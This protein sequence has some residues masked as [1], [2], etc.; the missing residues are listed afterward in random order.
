M[1]RY[2][3]LGHE[4]IGYVGKDYYPD[5]RINIG[6]NYCTDCWRQFTSLTKEEKE[7][8]Q[9]LKKRREQKNG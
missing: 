9:K 3:F 8:L 2:E 7:N 6:G 4:V 5:R 1:D